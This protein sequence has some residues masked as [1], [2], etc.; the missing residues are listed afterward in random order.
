MEIDRVAGGAGGLGGGFGKQVGAAGGAG[1]DGG[2][3]EAMSGSMTVCVG[4]TRVTGAAEQNHIHA[5]PV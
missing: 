1:A 3:Q 5:L 2:V 4:E